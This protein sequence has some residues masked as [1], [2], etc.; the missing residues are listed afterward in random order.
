MR[1]SDRVEHR[2]HGAGDGGLADV[3]LAHGAALRHHQHRGDLV[4]H[5]QR[6]QRI[7]DEREAARLHHHHAAQPAHIGAGQGA[8]RLVLPG[9]TH[10]HEIIVGRGAADQRREHIVG[11]I[12]DQP[13]VVFLQDAKKGVRPGHRRSGLLSI[14]SAALTPTP[15]TPGCK[16][17]RRCGML[18]N[19]LA[20]RRSGSCVGSPICS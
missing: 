11:N 5:D 4:R 6:R 13:D 8:Q 3:E 1:D 18:G 20:W 14:S 9:R 12:A 16:D 10:R 15:S 19:S 7:G 2:P 17:A